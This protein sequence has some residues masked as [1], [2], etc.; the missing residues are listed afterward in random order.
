MA[1]IAAP[2]KRSLLVVAV[3]TP[4]WASYLVKAF[5]WRSMLGDEGLISWL[6]GPFGIPQPERLDR[7]LAHVHVLLAPVHDPAHLR[8]ARA[9]LAVAARG[10]VGSGGRAVRTFFRVTLPLAFPAVVAGSIFTFSFTLGDYILPGLIADQQFIGTVDLQR[11]QLA[12]A[13]RRRL[14]DGADRGADRLPH[15]RPALGRL[16]SALGRWSSHHSHARCSGSPRVLTLAFIYVPLLVIAIY[17]FNENISQTWPISELHDEVV[18]RGVARRPGS[19]GPLAVGEGGPRRNGD[20]A[21]PG[22]ARLR[23]RRALPLLRQGDDLVPRHPADRAFRHHHRARAPG[24]DPQHPLAAGDRLLDLDDHHRPRDLLHRRRLQQL[25][26]PAAAGS[27][28][29]WRRRRPTSARIRGRRSA[30]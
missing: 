18:R 15:H 24:D 13:R 3:L 30:T 14:R 21:R 1:R 4:L 20:R 16:Q 29:R 25:R 8:G 19:P 26:R 28:G 27:Q 12:A 17:A 6:L 9:D 10:L 22:Y 23:R 7:P 11:A 2:R 5:A